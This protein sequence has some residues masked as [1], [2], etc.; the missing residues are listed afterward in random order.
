MTPTCVY[1]AFAESQILYFCWIPNIHLQPITTK[2]ESLIVP[3]PLPKKKTIPPIIL[4]LR[5]IHWAVLD[6]ILSLTLHILSIRRFYRLYLKNILKIEHHLH[7]YHSIPKRSPCFCFYFLPIL[8]LM[9][10][11]QHASHTDPNKTLMRSCHSSAP[12]PQWPQS[13]S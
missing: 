1:L 2:T 11:S 13:K 6:F 8:I 4:S 5:Q 3:F 10:H 7:C 12:K 9:A